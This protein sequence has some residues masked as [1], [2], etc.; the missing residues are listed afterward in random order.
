MGFEVKGGYTPVGNP[1]DEIIE[2]GKNY[3][4]IVLSDTGKSALKRFFLGSVAVKVL[5]KANHSVMI[6]RDTE[7]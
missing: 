2:Q 4:L 5:E 6:V 7:S 3:S 1:I